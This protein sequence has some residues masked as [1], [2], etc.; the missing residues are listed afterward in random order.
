MIP[1][2]NIQPEIFTIGPITVRWYGLMYVIGYLIGWKLLKSR[3]RLGLIRASYAQCESLITYVIIGMLLGA[4]IVYAYVYN[5][6]LYSTHPLQIFKVWEGGLSFHGAALGMSVA[7]ILFARKHKLKSYSVVDSLCYCGTPGLFFGRM[8]NFINGELYGRPTDS[9]FAMIFPTD[10][11]Q[12]P[13]HPSQLYQGLTEGVLLFAVLFFLQKYLIAKKIY[14]NGVISGAFAIL[15]GTFRFFTEFAR[16]P[17][18]QLGFVL[19]FLSMGQVLCLILIAVG[20][21]VLYHALKIEKIY[22]PLAQS[23]ATLAASP[24]VGVLSE[25]KTQSKKGRKRN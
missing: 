22:Q 9:S 2:P 19:G 14:R 15:Y 11:L 7:C 12:L 10:P 18:K 20:V 4:R 16:E 6:E 1:Y 13:R 25:K 17:D 23:E 8:G 5:W 3:A 21:A 24:V